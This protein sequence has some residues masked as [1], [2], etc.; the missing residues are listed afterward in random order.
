MFA[1]IRKMLDIIF[2]GDTVP[3]E[4]GKVYEIHGGYTP[5]DMY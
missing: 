2:I 5:Y 4:D 1:K 3:V